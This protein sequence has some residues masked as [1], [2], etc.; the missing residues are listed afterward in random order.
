MQD[1]PRELQWMTYL[2]EWHVRGT[3]IRQLPDYLA[4]FTQLSVLEIPQNAITELPPEIG[5]FVTACL[6]SAGEQTTECRSSSGKLTELRELN[7]SYN[8]LSRVP[9]ELGDCENLRRLELTGNHL[10]ELPFEVR[11]RHGPSVVVTH[12][13]FS[14]IP[15]VS[16]S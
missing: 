12:P 9:P 2:K 3:K 6:C 4:Q 5:E 13:Q 10:S 1:F 16:P 7:V 8:R 14:F 15:T 11:R